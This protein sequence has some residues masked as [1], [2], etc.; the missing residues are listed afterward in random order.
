VTA[1]QR[2]LADVV[3]LL[4]AV[5]VAGLIA[6]RRHRL[7]RSFTYFLAS[8]VIANRLVVWW[9]GTFF[10][11]EFWTV[12]EAC[13]ALLKFGVALEVASLVFRPFVGARPVMR[14]GVLAALLATSVVVAWVPAG[15]DYTQIVGQLQPR[16]AIGV[17]WIFS[18]TVALAAWHRIPLHD[19][20]RAIM[21]GFVP[22]LVVFSLLL[23]LLTQ[24]DSRADA[25]V[26][27]ADQVACCLV[28]A[29]WCYSVWRR[30]EM[31]AVAPAVIRELQPWR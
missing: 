26:S 13:Y 20:H 29:Y 30:E 6:R 11:L 8:I 5:A 2:F 31:P 15:D 27:Y 24:F 22:Y 17:V 19:F 21:L 28:M 3:V 10:N 4:A 7:C 25:F 9:P 14:F 18:V 16:V 23:S 12:K 1:L